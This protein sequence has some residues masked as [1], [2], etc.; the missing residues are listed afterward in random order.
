MALRP[1]TQDASGYKRLW[2][3]QQMYWYVAV[4]TVEAL[5]P[6]R[7]Q[8]LFRENLNGKR[9]NHPKPR[10]RR[11][12]LDQPIKQS[13]SFAGGDPEGG[14]AGNDVELGITL[15]RDSFAR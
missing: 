8:E 11:R 7:K 4:H 13:Q 1:E 6:C 3:S 10:G 9:S 2:H 5:T 12:A 15:P 14:M